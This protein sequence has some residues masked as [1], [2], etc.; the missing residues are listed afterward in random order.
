VAL[1]PDMVGYI[2]ISALWLKEWQDKHKQTANQFQQQFQTISVTTRKREK[3]YSL[4]MLWLSRKYQ[5]P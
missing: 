4:Q 1:P 3:C 5:T 2:V